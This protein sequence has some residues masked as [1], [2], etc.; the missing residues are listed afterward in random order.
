MIMSY[1]LCSINGILFSALPTPSSMGS[2]RP[3]YVLSCAG[4]L[5]LSFVNT[6]AGPLPLPLLTG[7]PWNP[8]PTVDGPTWCQNLQESRA[9]VQEY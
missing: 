6:L 1:G 3:S 9:E 8:P 2:V 4:D 5:E 7:L